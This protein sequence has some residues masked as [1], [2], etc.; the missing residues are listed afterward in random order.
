MSVLLLSAAYAGL[1]RNA[2]K[3]AE[4]AGLPQPVGLGTFFARRVKTKRARALYFTLMVSSPFVA[5]YL[6]EW[7][8]EPEELVHLL[9]IGL[10]WL[11]IVI[12][13]AATLP[14]RL[15]SLDAPPS[16]S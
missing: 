1:G 12:F 11:L 4:A 8:A 10:P 15:E 5:V 14:F 3:R 7:V 6:Y 9:L 13:A 16:D 2:E